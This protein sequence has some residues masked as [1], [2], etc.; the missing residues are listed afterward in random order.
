LDVDPVSLQQLVI[1]TTLAQAGAG[2][3]DPRWEEEQ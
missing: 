3:T 2:V 1:D